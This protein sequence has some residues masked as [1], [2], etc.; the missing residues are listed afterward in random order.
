MELAKFTPHAQ[1]LM[2]FEDVAIMCCRRDE[3]QRLERP[4]GGRPVLHVVL[5]DGSDAQETAHT[6]SSDWL[7]CNI[8][9]P[10]DIARV[11]ECAALLTC[12]SPKLHF[13]KKKKKKVQDVFLFFVLFYF[14]YFKCIYVCYVGLSTL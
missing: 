12:A 5:C 1:G 2:R 13:W 10:A 14:F 8:N 9:E 11:F 4:D 3:M 7:P 6:G